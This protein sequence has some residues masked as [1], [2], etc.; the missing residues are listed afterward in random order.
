MIKRCV[1]VSSGP[2]HLW[3]KNSQ[4]VLTREGKEISRIPIEDLG[5]L[6]I[7]NPSITY[8]HAALAAMMEKNVAVVVCGH[9][10]HPAG[11]LLPVEG[12]T[13]HGA[14]VAMQS[15]ATERAKNSLW[16]GIIAAKIRNQ[17][18]ALKIM[19]KEGAGLE[20]LSR[21][22]KSG[23]PENLE[24]Q[25]AQRYWPMLL[26]P[27]FRRSRDGG[28][29]NNLLNYGYMVLRAATARAVCGAGLH[30]SLGIHHRNQ[31]NGFALA[32]D[33]MEPVRP[34]VDLI[35]CGLWKE[36]K[37]ELSRESKE[38]LLGVLA[39]PVELSGQNSP[40]MTALQKSAASLREAL[41]GESGGLNI[42][43]PALSLH[44]QDR[45]DD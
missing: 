32:D 1:E 2:A 29:P 18:Y 30:P 39:A 9:D 21:R 22:V 10:H 40:L 31:Y 36:G 24:A 42:P 35:V 27:A 45:E 17:A 6:V 7:D 20:A 16:K 11:L 43:K 23:D 3:V 34:M 38:K 41:S 37:I 26:G 14:T 8:T 4:L 33:L 19:G 25:A 5:V 44:L 13:L 12:H 15:S 28:P